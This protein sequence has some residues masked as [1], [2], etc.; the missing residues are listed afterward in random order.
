MKTI[1]GIAI[2][3]ALVGVANAIDAPYDWSSKQRA[4]QRTCHSYC[5]NANGG[6][7]CSTQCQ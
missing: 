3:L 5:W 7:E 1:L 2:V 6:R 4:Q